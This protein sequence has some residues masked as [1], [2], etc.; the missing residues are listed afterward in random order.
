MG[1]NNPLDHVVKQLITGHQ[2]IMRTVTTDEFELF[3]REYTF[4]QLR[5]I[6][7]GHA[8]CKKFGIEDFVLDLL[9]T[10]QSAREHIRR[11]GYIE[12]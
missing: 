9:E 4:D 8:F 1:L 6:S 12:T 7:F 5:E 10:E 3:C 2:Q 11:V